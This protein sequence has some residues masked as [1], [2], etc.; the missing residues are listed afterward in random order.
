MGRPPK[1]PN[2]DVRQA[3]LDAALALFAERG[4]F[5]VGLRDIAR[6]A[7]VREGALYHYFAGKEALLAALLQDLDG[8]ADPVRAAVEAPVTD[9]RAFLVGLGT[10]LLDAFAAPRERQIFRVLLQDGM[11]LAAEGRYN[12]AERLGSRVALGEA[13]MARLIEAGHLR[14]A[15]VDRLALEFFAPFAVWK[16]LSVCMPDAPL[17]RERAAFVADHVDHFL[18]AAARAPAAPDPAP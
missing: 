9:L 11:R 4:Y 12:P 7:G 17:V 18:R 13:L 15:A 8:A 2:R 10:D 14:P 5:G 1:D 16:N 3:T 6:R